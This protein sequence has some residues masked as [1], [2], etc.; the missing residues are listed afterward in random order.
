MRIIPGNASNIRNGYSLIQVELSAERATYLDV[1]YDTKRLADSE[2]QGMGGSTTCPGPSFSWH[3]AARRGAARQWHGM[4][5]HD[6]AW[7]GVAWRGV[8][9]HGTARH[10]RARHGRAGHGMARHGTARHGITWHGMA[11]H[12]MAEW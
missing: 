5:W 10:S 11:W 12:G 6:M 7:R 3:G 4:A 1:R 8:A 9:G 2:C